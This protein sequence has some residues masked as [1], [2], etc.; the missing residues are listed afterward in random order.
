VWI[1]LGYS[2]CERQE[3]TILTVLDTKEQKVRN[4]R[5]NTLRNKPKPAYKPGGN[6]PGPNPLFNNRKPGF[7]AS[8]R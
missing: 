1:P 7:E 6:H 3:S 4:T 8:P 2:P 5:E